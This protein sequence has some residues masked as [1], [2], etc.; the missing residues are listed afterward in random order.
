MAPA[1][2]G[3]FSNALLVG[4]FGD[5]R[6]NA[7]DVTSGAFLGQLT[8]VGN[9][10][11]TIKGLWGLAVGNGT[12]GTDPN[13]LYFTAGTG[14]EQHGLF[15]SL[16]GLTPNEQFVAQTY[17]DLL[18]RP[19]DSAG[20][21]NWAAMISQ[22]TSRTAVAAAIQNSTEYRMVVVQQIYD[23]LLH[24]PADSNGLATFVN[25]LA[26]GGTVEQ[27]EAI[28]AS[29]DE[30]FQ[31][32]G[33]RTV[34]GFLTALYQDALNRAVDTSGRSAFDQALANGMSRAQ[35]ASIIFSST[36]YQQDLVQSDYQRFLRRAADSGGLAG[37]TAALQQGVRDEQVAAI[38]VGSDEYAARLQ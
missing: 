8:D 28:M 9:N 35:V 31:N 18:Q 20:L 36:E 3:S 32:R 38:L 15:G 21:A 23:S 7:F 29:S 2:F 16:R 17:L 11:V 14:G 26:N 5:G 25:F 6:I 19:V 37:F 12:N 33:G 4:N 27:A 13:T 22:G 10:P 34:N 1:Q 24:R 30:Y